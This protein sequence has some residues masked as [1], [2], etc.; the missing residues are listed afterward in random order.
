M[1]KLVAMLLIGM[2]AACGGSGSPSVPHTPDPHTDIDITEDEVIVVE[3]IIDLSYGPQLYD[4]VVPKELTDKP[5][6]MLVHGGGWFRGSKDDREKGSFAGV[7]EHYAQKGHPVVIINYTLGPHPM[8]L[9]DVILAKDYFSAQYGRPV[10]MLGVSAGG[11]LVTLAA[12][13][14]SQNVLGVVS[15]SGI[16]DFTA[17]VGLSPMES[18]VSNYLESASPESASPAFYDVDF[19]LFMIHGI[20]D[21]VVYVSQCLIMQNKFGIDCMVV[22]KKAHNIVMQ[23]YPEIEQFIDG[24]T[25]QYLLG[26]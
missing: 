23:D 18:I 14:S 6:I 4:L 12:Q 7:A 10:I 19:P 1:Y 25:E 13:Q 24:L 26:R 22:D 16:Y 5:V 3:Y 2:L 21:L 8:G 17:D 20:E 11:H 9:N 15:A